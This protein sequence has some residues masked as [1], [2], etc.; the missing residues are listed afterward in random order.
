MDQIRLSIGWCAIDAE[1]ES[2]DCVPTEDCLFYTIKATL[3]RQCRGWS[4][5]RWCA[6]GSSRLTGS[7]VVISSV[8]I[9]LRSDRTGLKKERLFD[10]VSGFFN[11]FLVK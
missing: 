2:Q 6:V 7:Q 11:S 4:D 5:N 1:L 8:R 9:S 10:P 3:H